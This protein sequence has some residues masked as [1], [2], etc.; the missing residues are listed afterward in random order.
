[1]IGRSPRPTSLL[2][3]ARLR[4]RG[5]ERVGP[6]ADAAVARRARDRAGRRPRDGTAADRRTFLESR[7]SR[8]CGDASDG[9]IAS[10]LA[11]ALAAAEVGDFVSE[12][13][14]TT[15][16]RRCRS[17]LRRSA[18]ADRRRPAVRPATGPPPRRAGTSLPGP[19]GC[20][21]DAGVGDEGLLVV[22]RGRTLFEASM[23]C[24]SR[25]TIWTGPPRRHEAIYTTTSSR[26]GTRRS[27]GG[28]PF[29]ARL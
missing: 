12:R 10:V 2:T 13:P 15:T 29:R 20:E 21:S 27:R 16:T 1:V 24:T 26:V 7:A 17:D 9:S 23:I 28:G 14:A 25:G 11:M 4:A 19:S 6:H 22:L 3:T 18:H 5:R 8:R